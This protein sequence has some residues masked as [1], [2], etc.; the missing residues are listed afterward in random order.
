MKIP[1]SGHS[2]VY[3]S[4]RDLVFAIGGFNSEKGFLKSV[5]F[6]DL[7]TKE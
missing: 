4:E 5:E 6:F 3:H 2:L 1:R 7:S